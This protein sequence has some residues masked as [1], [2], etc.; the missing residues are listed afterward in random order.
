MKCYAPPQS[1]VH[2]ACQ[3]LRGKSICPVVNV[4]SFRS[5]VMPRG[6]M[7]VLSC[8]RSARYR[9]ACL[10]VCFKY[11]IR[12]GYSS[13]YF[14]RRPSRVVFCS[15]SLGN[16]RSR[17]AMRATKSL[18]ACVRLPDGTMVLAELDAT[19]C[20]VL[21]FCVGIGRTALNTYWRLFHELDATEPNT[22]ASTL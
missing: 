22:Y 17:F 11:S 14:S 3:W 21:E 6:S 9:A 5:S 1:T 8:R 2:L 4:V 12:L 18:S 19:A 10:A 16:S 20:C 7:Q 13:G 15:S